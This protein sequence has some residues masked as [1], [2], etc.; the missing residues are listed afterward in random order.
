MR[1]VVAGTPPG[2]SSLEVRSSHH[3]QYTTPTADRS[4]G[5]LIQS[6]AA[7]GSRRCCTPG[8]RT[9]IVGRT[10]SVSM[11][12]RMAARSASLNVVVPP[13]PIEST[14]R[15]AWPF[16]LRP[17]RAPGSEA[18]GSHR[19]RRRR[20][21]WSSTSPRR[22]AGPGSGIRS[23]RASSSAGRGLHQPRPRRGSAPGTTLDRTA[24]TSRWCAAGPAVSAAHEYWPGSVTV[25]HTARSTRRAV[26]RMPGA[27]SRNCRR[28]LLARHTVLPSMA[29]A[30]AVAAAATA[31]ASCARWLASN[32]ERAAVSISASARF[33][34][35]SATCLVS[36]RRCASRRMCSISVESPR[37]P[38][39]P[40]PAPPGACGRSRSE[41]PLVPGPPVPA[42]RHGP[43]RPARLRRHAPPR[44]R[45]ASERPL[46]PPRRSAVERPARRE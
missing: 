26:R 41:S 11:C 24:A 3:R 38:G 31:S 5:G 20:G 22:S 23:R 18:A 15:R 39:P 44:A 16:D 45:R 28:G 25:R 34:R 40:V 21:S 4:A 19:L 35:T 43:V 10:A 17:S 36:A 42:P 1:G 37:V 32:A 7:G 46:T 8:P 33:A 2:P 12:A 30:C 13:A 6:S 9:E 27:R 14:D 29:A